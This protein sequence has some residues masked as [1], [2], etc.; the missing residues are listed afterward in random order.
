MPITQEELYHGAA[1]LNL[2]EAFGRELPDHYFSIKNLGQRNFYTITSKRN[3]LLTKGRELGAGLI[4]KTSSK[5]RTPW[6]Y[7]FHKPHQE[8]MKRLYSNY[9]QV[10]ILLIAGE[11]GIACLD[12]GS[13]GEVL[14]EK[15][16]EQEWVS[17][18]RKPGEYYRVA[19]NDGTREK[20][21]APN[22]FPYLIVDYFRKVLT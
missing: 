15:F 2:M 12:Y 8:E 6:R 1:V 13:L 19:G 4:I 14:D 9:G 5:R 3:S 16:E 21:L 7:N 22:Q 10:F 11:D 18:K 20:G 17:V